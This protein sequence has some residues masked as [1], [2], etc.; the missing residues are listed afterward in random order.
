VTPSTGSAQGGSKIT[1]TGTNF[2]TTLT[3]AIGGEPITGI[4]VAANG[5]SFTG[6]APAHAVGGPFAVSVTTAAGTFSKANAFTYTNGINIEPNFAPS[7]RLSGADITVIGTGF[8]GMDFSGTDGNTPRSAD[9]HVY[10][11]DGVYN[12]AGTTTKANG[13]VA[14]CVNVLVIE[15]DELICQLSLAT[16]LTTAGVYATK[17][18]RTV[19]IDVASSDATITATTGTFSAADVGAP[20]SVPS[21]TEFASGTTIASVT[22]ATHAELSTTTTTAS[23][24]SVAAT[25]G[26]RVDLTNI[27]VAS[28][29][30][31]VSGSNGTFAASDVGQ[32]ITSGTKF[33]AGTIITS[34][35][36]NGSSATLSQPA[37]GTSTTATVTILPSVAVSDGTY[38]LTIVS[39]GAI[40]AQADPMFSKSVVSNGSTFTV[41]DY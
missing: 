13:E 15:D 24:G 41:A 30:S 27:N 14:E 37:I 1:V 7:N 34:V 18:T 26:P 16:S 9:A 12:P 11:V 39:S 38:T 40:G 35:A 2:P 36:A 8:R 23:T 20:I 3:A 31:T 4:Q 6:E 33:T 32:V 22:D 28:G 5:Q 17:P 10:L 25:V 19:M 21:N 29:S